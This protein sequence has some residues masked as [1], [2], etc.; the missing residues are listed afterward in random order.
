MGIVWVFSFAIRIANGDM[1]TITSTLSRYEF[2]DNSWDTFQH[3]LQVAKLDDDVFPFDIAEIAQTLLEGSALSPGGIRTAPTRCILSAGS[4]SGLLR[5]GRKAKRKEHGAKRED[6]HF[7]LH[8]FL[9]ALDPLV[10]RHLPFSLD[11]PI[12][13]E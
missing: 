12:R 3:S 9:C 1:A 8:A 11:H 5:L 2:G 10:T 7:F 4:F 13:P 6:R